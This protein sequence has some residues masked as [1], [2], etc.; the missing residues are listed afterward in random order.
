MTLSTRALRIGDLTLLPRRAAWSEKTRTL[1]VADLH[2][3]KGAA[4][5]AG[6]APAPTGTT[7]ATLLRLGELCDEMGAARLIALGDF[8][9]ARDSR[10]ARLTAMLT[11]WRR[12]RPELDCL[13][14]RG[15]HDRHAGDPPEECGFRCVDEPFVEGEVESRHYP[16]EDPLS[17]GPTAL[18]G[19][20]HPVVRLEGPGRDALRAPC[21]VVEGRQ[22]V[23]PA[24]GEFT[25]G[26]PTRSRAGVRLVV[27]T[28]R[29]LF[30]IGAAF[31][32]GRG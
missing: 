28:D 3:G 15:N 24:F 1:W 29:E 21:F 9:H 14:V 2:L 18:A 5:R 4:F 30:V 20:L 19:H 22:I 23:L 13:I 31:G 11:A 16:L 7:E 26:S 8:L 25:G 27:T 32:E 17:V 6:G 12:R 10:S